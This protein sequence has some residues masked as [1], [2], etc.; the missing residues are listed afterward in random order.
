M[1]ILPLLLLFALLL[2]G[3]GTIKSSSRENSLSVV[4]SSFGNTLR[5]GDP[6]G[7]YRFLKPGSPAAEAEQR[8]LDDIRVTEYRALQPPVETSEMHAVGKARIRYVHR[9]RQIEKTII[10]EQLWEYDPEQKVWFRT[11]PIPSFD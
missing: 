7:V 1:K 4:L 8:N 5:W 3:C 2:G 6:N 10:D 9:E 11:N